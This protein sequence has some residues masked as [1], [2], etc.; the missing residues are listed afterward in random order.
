MKNSQNTKIS[1]EKPNFFQIITKPFRSLHLET[2]LSLTTAS[3][4][5][6]TITKSS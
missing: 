5:T 1:K 2:I 3:L 6:E 4:S